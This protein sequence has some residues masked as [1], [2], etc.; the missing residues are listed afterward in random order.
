MACAEIQQSN[1]IAAAL[2]IAVSPPP[3]SIRVGNQVITVDLS[4][5]SISSIVA[6]I[7]AAGG[8][9]STEAIPYGDETRFRLI[10][11]A[12]A[13]IKALVERLD[14]AGERAADP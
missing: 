5:D 3:A 4:T 9:A 11:E 13:A 12:E 10:A 7:N 6:K 1:A 8:Q 2:G 14:E